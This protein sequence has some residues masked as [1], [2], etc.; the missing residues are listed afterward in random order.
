M[1]LLE[2]DPYLQFLPSQLAASAVALA[3]HTLREEVWPHELELS[4]G[5]S[6]QDL[7]GCISHL[8]K[9]F[10]SAPSLPQQA[11]QEKYKS[12]K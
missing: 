12:N 3:R 5:Y 1:S 10:K 2:A 6:L 9:T 11:I 7:K 4:S 8:H